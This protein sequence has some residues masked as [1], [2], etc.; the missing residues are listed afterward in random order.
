MIIKRSIGLMQASLLL[1]SSLLLG[2]LLSA[3]VIYNSLQQQQKDFEEKLNNILNLSIG[4]ATNAAW[5][6]DTRLA[7]QVL[8]GVFNQSGVLEVEIRATLLDKDQQVLAR[9]S[10]LPPEYNLLEKWLAHHFFSNQSVIV[11]PLSINN[12]ETLKEAGSLNI[13]FDPGYQAEKFIAHSSDSLILSFLEAFLIGLLLLFIS[14]WLIT[15]PIR[16]ATT[17]II[18]VNIDD[19]QTEAQRIPVPLIHR[20]NEL[21]RLFNHTN[22]LLDRLKISQSKLLHLATKDPLTGLANRN[23]IKDFVSATLFQHGGRY[24]Y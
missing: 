8:K 1:L 22:D 6:L 24:L 4:S 3:A 9:M 20:D 10:R 13:I 7:E 16:R 17:S 15:L 2:L 19:L 11:K 5:A 18:E 12:Q 14:Q 21:G 23:L